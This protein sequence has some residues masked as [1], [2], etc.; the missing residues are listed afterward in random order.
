MFSFKGL[1][2]FRSVMLSAAKH[3]GSSARRRRALENNLRFFSRDCGIRMTKDA[4]GFDG[5]MPSTS[6]IQ[7]L[8]CSGNGH[9]AQS[10]LSCMQKSS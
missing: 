4:F 10:E 7:F 9:C 3:L 6:H 1:R 5:S 2:L 8:I